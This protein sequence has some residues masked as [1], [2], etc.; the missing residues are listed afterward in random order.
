VAR[1]FTDAGAM[2]LASIAGQ[3]KLLDGGV[4]AWAFWIFRT[5]APAAERGLVGMGDFTTD[6]GWWVNMTATGLIN[7]M[8]PFATANRVRASSTATALNA[9]THVIVNC[10]GKGTASTDFTFYI[11]GK[12]EAGTSTANGAGA[13]PIDGSF[14]VKIGPGPGTATVNGTTAPPAQFGP[15]AFWNRVLTDAEALALAAGAHPLRFRPGLIETWDLM[16]ASHETATLGKVTLIAGATVPANSAVNPP[17]EPMPVGLLN[18]QRLNPH[19]R[20]Y[21]RARYFQTVAAAFTPLNRRTLNPFG[22]HVGG[23]TM[24]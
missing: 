15:I 24:R 11:N 5:A 6:V 18:R 2:A 14:A 10:A 7:A 4:G 22:S 23:R 1:I 9:W 8:M 20:S 12:P 3:G 16:S 13:G 17:V 21:V 19:P